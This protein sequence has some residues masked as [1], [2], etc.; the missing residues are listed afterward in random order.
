MERQS[1]IVALPSGFSFDYSNLYGQ[2]LITQQD[3]AA[4]AARTETAHKAIEH[5]RATGEIR[6]HLSKDGTPE[7][8]LFSQLPYV[9]EGNINSPASI[10]RLK[11]FGQ[12]LRYKVDAVLSF[13]IGG[14]YLGNKVL[15]DVHCGEFWN[16][17]SSEERQGYPKLYFSGNNIDPRRTTELVEQIKAEAQA[18]AAHAGA[19]IG[20]DC[21]AALAMTGTGA[22]I[23]NE[24]SLRGGTTKQSRFSCDVGN[25]NDQGTGLET[26]QVMLIVISKSG[27]TLD[28]MSNFMVIYDAL[29]QVSN[30]TVQVV[31]VTDPAKGTQETLLHKL[32]D[33]QGWPMFSV[34]DGVGGRFSVFSEVGLVTAACIGFD[35]EAFLA[36]ARAMDEACKTEDIWR[37]P[38]MLNAVLKYLAAANYGRDIEVFMPYADYLKSVAEWYVQLLAES[39]GKRTDRAGREVFYGRTPIVAV[40]TTDMHAQTQLH[41][42][43]K[44]DKVVQ[45]VKVAKWTNDLP[46]PDVFP[47]AAKLSDISGLRL[48]Q[49]LDAARQANAAALSEDGRF[50]ATFALPEMNAFHLG[51]LLYLLALSVAYEGELADVDAFDQPGVETYKR[52]LGPML[53]KM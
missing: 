12:S 25:G 39:L 9:E 37:N 20:G 1:A 47:T 5:M 4:I 30:I 53:K 10:A 50:N 52:L 26:Y 15:F 11:Q 8:V 49:A 6:G 3:V 18:A 19:E 29:K 24:G 2:G 22:E 13:G 42:D 34:P 38:A 33:E 21:H 16:G 32:A 35:F 31:A 48:S 17:K 45:F 51:E 36:G 43:G 14:S 40:G 7:K 23:G 46:I 41:Q 28:T 27:S 44:K